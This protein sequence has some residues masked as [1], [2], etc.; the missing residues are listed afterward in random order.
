MR[1]QYG[2][3]GKLLTP[4]HRNK[5]LPVHRKIKTGID[6]ALEFFVKDNTQD[7][8][9]EMSDITGKTPLVAKKF[10]SYEQ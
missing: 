3:I 5:N 6:T 1:A 10:L 8:M 9:F 2:F 4:L 7:M